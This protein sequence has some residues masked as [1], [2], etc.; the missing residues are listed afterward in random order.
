MKIEEE[1]ESEGERATDAVLKTAVGVSEVR[2]AVRM[3]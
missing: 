2:M 3:K 1:S